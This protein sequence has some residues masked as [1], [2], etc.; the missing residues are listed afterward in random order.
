MRHLHRMVC[1]LFVLRLISFYDANS[2]AA[3]VRYVY[4]ELGR[5]V[6]VIDTAGQTA[7]YN[8]D[9]VGNLLSI[10]TQSSSTVAILEF[11][12]NNL[13]HRYYSNH[14]GKWVQRNAKSKHR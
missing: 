6:A 4:D 8:Y 3:D 11:T 7:I 12:P 10:T 2:L 14:M 13:A 1:F 9:A 5:L